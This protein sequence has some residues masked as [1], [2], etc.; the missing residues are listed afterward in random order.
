MDDTPA[1]L[2]RIEAM[3]HALTGGADAAVAEAPASLAATALAMRRAALR[4]LGQAMADGPAQAILLDLHVSAAEGRRVFVHDACV[5][6]GVPMSTALRWV[7]T[8]AKAGLVAKAP[9]AKDGR[10]TLL[11]LTDA[12]R[13][14]IDALLADWAAL[15]R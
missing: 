9:D 2:A 15:A 3:L 11:S 10:R 8:L 12:G 4:H 13:A 14:R 7:A 1:R 6:S 5:A